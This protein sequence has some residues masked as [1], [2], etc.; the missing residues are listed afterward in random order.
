MRLSRNAF[1]L[2]ELLVV[3]SIIG[4]LVGLLL[5]AVQSAREA[6]RRTQCINNLHQIGLATHNFHDT[7][8]AFPPGRLQPRPG[9]PEEYSCGGT[10]TTWLVRIMPFLEQRNMESGWDYTK[11]YADH[12]ESVRKA[13]TPI[14]CCPSRRSL[15]EAVG[16][17]LIASTSTRKVRLPCGCW[18]TVS[19]E[20]SVEL[21]GSL[22]DYGGNHGDLTPGS[23]GAATDF[24]NG[25]NGTGVIISSRARC[26]A[27]VPVDWVDRIAMRDILDGSS[28]T[29]L[30]GEMHVPMGKLGKSPED[31]FIFNGDSFSNFS[32]IGGPTMPI[33][34]D[35]RS[36]GSGLVSWGSWHVGV[37]QFVLSDGST[38]AL[39]ASTDTEV[40]GNLCNRR[41][42][43]VVAIHE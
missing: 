3:I 2:V 22:G 27:G 38:R 29:L 35:P 25:G 15:S 8:R 5:P 10:Q 16:T 33:V 43:N 17:G 39:S 41:D 23:T 34:E 12:P 36:E 42:G 21:P 30:A 14:Y 26:R 7:F 31:A 4:V 1:T 11:A 20:G 24:Y 6:A 37:C 32:R 19:E 9:E 40:L 13:N 28:N 18:V